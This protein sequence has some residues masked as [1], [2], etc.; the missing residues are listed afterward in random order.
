MAYASRKKPQYLEQ[1]VPF[2]IHLLAH[3]PD[4]NTAEIG[5]FDGSELSPVQEEA[6]RDNE[7]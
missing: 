2:L 7:V 4:F 1:N 5:V 6:L 3:H